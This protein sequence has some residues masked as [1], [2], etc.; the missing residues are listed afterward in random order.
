MER[1]RCV[2]LDDCS[3]GGGES[4]AEIG[5]NDI[6]PSEPQPNLGH[7]TDDVVDQLLRH[8]RKRYFMRV[9]P[10]A[11]A[12]R[13]LHRMPNAGRRNRL[14]LD[15]LRA[16]REEG[17][18]VRVHQLVTAGS[19]GVHARVV[20]VSDQVAYGRYPVTLNRR[21]VTADC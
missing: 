2:D 15:L 14:K 18:V 5:R 11:V 6:D 3:S 21:R 8:G 13:V 17:I 7:G 19:G 4:F 12:V 16:Q 10:T 9:E 1:G 20:L